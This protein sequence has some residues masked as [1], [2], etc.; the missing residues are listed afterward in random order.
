MIFKENIFVALYGLSLFKK[1]RKNGLEA[2][3]NLAKN[4]AHAP[5]GLTIPENVAI[6]GK[7]IVLSFC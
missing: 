7:V 4:N 3:S 5:A 2:V 6:T 1:T